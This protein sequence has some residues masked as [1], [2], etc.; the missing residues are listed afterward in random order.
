MAPRI[1]NK[2]RVSRLAASAL[3]CFGL[4][5]HLLHRRESANDSGRTSP[6][7]IRLDLQ[8]LTGQA[9][10]GPKARS[11]VPDEYC[12]RR[13]GTDK[14]TTTREG[15]ST[16]SIMYP[17]ETVSVKSEVSEGRRASMTRVSLFVTIHLGNKG[18]SQS[19]VNICASTGRQDAGWHP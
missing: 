6:S 15:E 8:V 7:E 3:G 4:K 9:H 13:Y 19:E 2:F 11:E 1:T 17:I 5:A 16:K 18:K 14:K 12:Q 10:G